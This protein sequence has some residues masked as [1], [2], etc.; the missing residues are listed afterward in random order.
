MPW[1]YNQILNVR[2]K[3]SALIIEEY[4]LTDSSRINAS[5]ESFTNDY[6]ENILLKAVTYL[7]KVKSPSATDTF[8]IEIDIKQKCAMALVHHYYNGIYQM[9]EFYHTYEDIYEALDTILQG[10]SPISI[11]ERYYPIEDVLIVFKD[12]NT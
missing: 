3:I 2:N 6:Y 8:D 7:I 1:T 10:K 9:S 12:Q 11:T 5:A 4:L